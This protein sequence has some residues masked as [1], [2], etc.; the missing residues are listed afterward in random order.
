MTHLFLRSTLRK[1][2]SNHFQSMKKLLLLAIFCL[3]CGIIIGLSFNASAQEPK[4][5]PSWVKS[6][7]KLWV[8]GDVGDAD[9]IKA[10]QWLVTH[11]IIVL[12]NNSLTNTNSQ[13]TSATSNNSLSILLPT[14]NDLGGLWKILDFTTSS[15]FNI[16]ATPPIAPTQTIEQIFEKT[17][18]TPMTVVTIDVASFK[19]GP[20]L[21]LPDESEAARVYGISKKDFESQ[22]TGYKSSTFVPNPTDNKAACWMY[23][24]TTTQSTKIDMFCEKGYTVFI[25]DATGND[26][27]M[28]DDVKKMTNLILPKLIAY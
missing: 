7:A 23:T 10:I 16:Q 14:S 24:I 11:G 25:L 17:S 1:S 18:T 2:N 26:L 5:I 21:A 12:P 4:S 28:S 8:N 27:S 6:T 3:S 20:G 19:S 15:R 13:T 9:F 22:H